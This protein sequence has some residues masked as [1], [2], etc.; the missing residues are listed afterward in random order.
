MHTFFTKRFFQQALFLTVFSSACSTSL[1]NDLYLDVNQDAFFARFDGTHASNGLNISLSA[2]FND[3]NGDVYS[4][5][6]FKTGDLSRNDSIT[7]GL[8]AKL[9]YF[10]LDGDDVQAL[11]LG[12][13]LFYAIPQAPD[14]TVGAE[15]YYAPS[16]T[17]S[18]DLDN[19][20][21]FNFR[22]NYQAFENGSIY[23]GYRLIE[24]DT[25]AGDFEVDDSLHI[26]I[27]LSI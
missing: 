25:G 12:G 16:I 2:L 3:E 8:G 17:V 13:S 21:D 27:K 5:G 22:V 18:D 11:S 7:A 24:L 4:V 15:L 6:I 20:I 23:A 1:A 26:G 10:N 19:T 14:I 9:S